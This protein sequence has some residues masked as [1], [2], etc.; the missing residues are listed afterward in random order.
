MPDIIKKH[1]DFVL[2]L[3]AYQPELDI[4]NVK[5]EKVGNGLT[6]ITLDVA[7]KGILASHTKL[8]ERSY[9]IKRIQVK[10]NTGGATRSVISGRKN[11]FVEFTEGLS[12]QQLTWLVKGSGKLTIE[13]GSPY[14]W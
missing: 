5:T 10:V 4:L 1:T 3:A 6:R 9:W 8:G 11:Q 7:N 2:K 12:S 14:H 13:A